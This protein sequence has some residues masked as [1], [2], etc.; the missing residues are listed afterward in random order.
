MKP[1]YEDDLVTLYLGD[2]R[3]ITAWTAADV[4]VTDPPYGQA[5]RSS[6]AP[7][8]S[9][10][11]RSIAGDEDTSSRDAALKLWGDRPR[12]VFE[13]RKVEP[14][15]YDARLI[16]HKPGAGMGALS[17]PWQPDYEFISV[18]GK[19]FHGHRG[20]SILTSPLREFRGAQKHP[21]AKPVGLMEALIEK[22]PAGTIADPFVGSGSTLVA[23]RNLGRRVIGVELE[24][25]YCELV[26]SRLQQQAFDFGEI[27]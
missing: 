25:K 1:Y 16:W 24:E 14:L 5:Y 19:G 11:A 18:K 13:G 27:A 15:P 26:A 8:S 20:S 21:H 4:L 17:I 22:C 12:V 9:P 3:E 2:C 10:L 6:Y 7:A 23:A